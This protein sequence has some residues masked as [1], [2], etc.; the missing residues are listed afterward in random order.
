LCAQKIWQSARAGAS[1]ME[2]V[3]AAAQSLFGHMSP[4][5]ALPTTEARAKQG[6]EGDAPP[7]P[8][9]QQNQKPAGPRGSSITPEGPVRAGAEGPRGTHFAEGTREHD[10]EV[11]PSVAASPCSRWSNVKDVIMR[12][13]RAGASALGGQAGAGVSRFSSALRARLGDDRPR[14]RNLAGSRSTDMRSAML[15]RKQNTCACC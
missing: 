11:G 7:Q 6:A 13:S 5:Q 4:S 10:G 8:L 2:G 15:S 14:K 3:A 1:T 12:G 9:A